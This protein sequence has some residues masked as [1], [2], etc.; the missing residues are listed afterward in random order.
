[1]PVNLI[2]RISRPRKSDL[3][4]SALELLYKAVIENDA[5]VAWCDYYITFENKKRVIAQP[6]FDTPEDAV[7]GMLRGT[8]KYNV[9]NKLIKRKLYTEHNIS[10]P[11][12]RGMGEDMTIIKLFCHL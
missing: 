2:Q 9:W 11:E 1:M 7:R 8:M 12:G 6:C 5:D 4:K 10:F 3:E